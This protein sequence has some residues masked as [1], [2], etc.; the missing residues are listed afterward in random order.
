MA[1]VEKR[2]CLKTNIVMTLPNP[3]PEFSVSAHMVYNELNACKYISRLYYTNGLL[4]FQEHVQ[5]LKSAY[6][7]SVMAFRQASSSRVCH[8]YSFIPLVIVNKLAFPSQILDAFNPSQIL[9]D[10]T[11]PVPDRL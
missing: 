7:L 2:S 6:V 9:F 5:T 8:N 4:S 1:L 11:H 3:L 10:E